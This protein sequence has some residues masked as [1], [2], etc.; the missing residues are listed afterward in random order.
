[1]DLKNKMI[2]I[3]IAPKYQDDEGVAPA[4]YLREL[5]ADVRYVGIQKGSCPGK[6]QAMV[7]VET[8]VNEVQAS[9]FDGLVIPGGAAPETL[10]LHKDALAFVK[11]FFDEA[12]PVAAIC[13]GPQ[14]LMSAG[15][16]RGRTM[17]CYQGIRDDL[18]NAGAQYLDQEVVIDG[19]L[20]TSR[21]PQDL[22]AF[23]KAFAELLVKYD[24]EKTPWAHASPAQVLEFA[25]GNEIK[26]Y[27]V[28][29]SLAKCAKDKVA[30]AKFKFLAET[31][32]GHREKLEELYMKLY[33]G[34]KPEPREMGER[35][36][37]GHLD[38]DA[39]DDLLKIL[40][41]AVNAEEAAHS[42]YAQI[43]EKTRHAEAKKLF[44][45]LAEEELEHRR[46]L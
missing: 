9:N 38:V 14:V 32:R 11:G 5:G 34:R 1:M 20:V 24:R 8:T 43:A 33:G 19:N 2:A 15:L 13:H 42:M 45:T 36:G 27:D 29:D 3:L 16:A 17:T 30:K 31:E 18:M 7:Q 6:G 44:Q 22:L 23:N 40:T 35:G 12:K 39:S 10:R 26:A 37:E 21:V 25:I 4:K 28:Y 46:L 41:L